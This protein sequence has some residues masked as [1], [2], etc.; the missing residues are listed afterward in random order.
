MRCNYSESPFLQNWGRILIWINIDFIKIYGHTI[1]KTDFSNDFPFKHIC[2]HILCR[3]SDTG[4]I[5]TSP[6][7]LLCMWHTKPCMDFP[8]K[9]RFATSRF[10]TSL[11]N[12]GFMMYQNQIIYV[13]IGFKH[14]SGATRISQCTRRYA[15]RALTDPWGLFMPPILQCMIHHA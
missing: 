13:I 7:P 5:M 6:R 3:F 8:Q 9:A 10:G 11:V 14:D 15:P 1:Y 2:V 4:I 12:F